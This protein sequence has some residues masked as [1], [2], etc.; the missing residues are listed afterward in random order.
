MSIHIYEALVDIEQRLQEVLTDV[1]TVKEQSFCSY[2][3]DITGSNDEP[4]D[5]NNQ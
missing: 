4:N 2:G 5:Q 1:R 3:A